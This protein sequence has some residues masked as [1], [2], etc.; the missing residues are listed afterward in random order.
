MSRPWLAFRSHSPRLTPI[1]CRSSY[2]RFI[3]KLGSVPGANW[4]ERWARW[5]AESP[6][7]PSSST[8]PPPPA[9]P[10]LPPPQPLPKRISESRAAIEEEL[11]REDE[12]RA[13]QKED[14]RRADIFYEVGLT[15]RCWDVWRKGREWVTVSLCHPLRRQRMHV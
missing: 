15:G 5:L 2:Y 7:F 1:C 6:D 9:S 10:P 13:R 4:G 12:E 8:S 14:E 11:R 3:L